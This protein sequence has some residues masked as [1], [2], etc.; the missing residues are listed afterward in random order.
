MMNIISPLISQNQLLHQK[1]KDHKFT[2]R[3]LYNASSNARTRMNI[4]AF[5]I[6]IM[7]PS[8]NEQIDLDALILFRNDVTWFMH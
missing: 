7:R 4:E 3:I 2:W 1:N 8:L 5:F 6:A